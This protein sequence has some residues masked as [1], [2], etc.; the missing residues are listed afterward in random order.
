VLYSG[1]TS[2]TLQ[3]QFGDCFS[4]LHISGPDNF[5][6][7]DLATRLLLRLPTC[8]GTTSV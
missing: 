4:Q 3:L 1:L 5:N 7:L 8:S 6:F 2:I